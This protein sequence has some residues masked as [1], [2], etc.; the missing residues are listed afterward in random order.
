MRIVCCRWMRG[1]HEYHST[2]LRAWLAKFLPLKP[3][4]KAS[5]EILWQPGG[6][7]FVDSHTFWLMKRHAEHNDQLDLHEWITED[8][9]EMEKLLERFACKSK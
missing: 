1:P 3:N 9:L 5:G 6:L 4:R 2:R 7:V 8:S